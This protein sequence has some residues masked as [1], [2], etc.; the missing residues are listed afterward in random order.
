MHS[1][2]E[3]I[4]P[5]AL[6]IGN[7]S[8]PGEGVYPTI[9]TFGYVEDVMF[10]DG[11]VKPFV[12]YT[13][14]TRHADDGRPLHTET[15]YIR[16]VAGAPEWVLASPTGVTEVHVGTATLANGGLDMSFRTVTVAAT[17]SAKPVDSVAR[18]LRVRGDELTYELHMAAV[19]QQHQIHL[20]AT[21][22]RGT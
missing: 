12:A 1:F 4:G 21:L 22:R 10:T 6:L 11:G 20:R 16:W 17:P 9:D 19:G 7:W 8:G 2:D 5:L 14:R 13:Q 18:V 3:R 15:G